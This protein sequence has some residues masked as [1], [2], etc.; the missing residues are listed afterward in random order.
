MGH[1]ISSSGIE[2]DPAKVASVKEWVEP[3]NASEIRSFL[4]LAGYYRKF[5]QGFSSIAVP[6]TSL[7]KKKQ[8]SYGVMNVRKSL[9]L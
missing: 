5:I 6:L 3:N 1:I 7:T 4:G 2:V 8:N 9:T